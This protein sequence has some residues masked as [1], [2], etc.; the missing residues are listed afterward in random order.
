MRIFST[1]LSRLVAVLNRS[2]CSH[3]LGPYSGVLRTVDRNPIERIVGA[4]SRRA[5][6]EL[7]IQLLNPSNFPNYFIIPN[8]TVSLFAEH[9][10]LGG[11]VGAGRRRFSSVQLIE[12]LGCGW[13]MNVLPSEKEVAARTAKP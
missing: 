4:L 5:G 8:G 12:A 1:V 11:Q 6:R 3:R 7:G 13:N 9:T 10:Y 2:L